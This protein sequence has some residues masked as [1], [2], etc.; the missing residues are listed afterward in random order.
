[1]NELIIF[2]KYEWGKEAAVIGYLLYK[3]KHHSSLELY[4][5]NC[6]KLRYLVTAYKYNGMIIFYNEQT[7]IK[8]KE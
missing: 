8:C 2:R 5:K 7:Q 6:L 1:M 3:I 4:I